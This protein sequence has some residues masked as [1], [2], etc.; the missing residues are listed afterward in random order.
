MASVHNL[1]IIFRIRKHLEIAVPLGGPKQYDMV[2]VHLPDRRHRTL[3]QS[4]Q[5][6]V[7]LIHLLEIRGYR[8]INQ[9]I[10]Q[11]HRL[12]FIIVR[13]PSPNRAE[14]LLALL[15][16]EQPGITI[17]IVNIIS[18]LATRS[19]VHVQDQVN[20]IVTAPAD[21]AV[22]TGKTILIGFQSHII[23]I[24]EQFIMER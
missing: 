19:I 7:H 17:A 2:S 6:P 14:K 9:L 13:D 10:A 22:H 1:I 21:N 18:G 3:M 20:A 23:L 5:L 15:T 8:L 11:N 24:R 16:L 4:L 12:I